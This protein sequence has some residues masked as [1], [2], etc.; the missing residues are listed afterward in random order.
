MKN[1]QLIGLIGIIILLICSFLPMSY[2]NDTAI[3]LFPVQNNANIE[4]IW[5]WK[6]IAAFSVTFT[7]TSLI[8]IYLI[9]KN[10]KPG[11]LITI[12]LGLV[13]FLFIFISLWL[14]SIKTMDLTE[15]NF[16]YSWW[17]LAVFVGFVLAY[18]GGAKIPKKERKT[19]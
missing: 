2:L 17:L 16:S 12:S 8:C 19:T 4:G 7:L 10:Y 15:F 14:T 6:D 3:T 9:I 1:Y 18:Y 13:S 5:I 11:F